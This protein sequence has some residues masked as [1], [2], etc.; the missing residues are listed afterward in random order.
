MKGFS[1]AV[2]LLLYHVAMIV[3]SSQTLHLG[4]NI[5]IFWETHA[6]QRKEDPFSVV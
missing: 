2:G 4:M 1:K 5:L 3:H 6:A